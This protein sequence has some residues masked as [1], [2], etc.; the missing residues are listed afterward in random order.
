MVSR[1][2]RVEPFCF[3]RLKERKSEAVADYLICV[4]HLVACVDFNAQEAMHI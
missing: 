4:L 1:A 3:I 2:V